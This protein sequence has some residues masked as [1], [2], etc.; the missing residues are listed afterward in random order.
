[1]EIKSSPRERIMC[2]QVLVCV[3]AYVPMCLCA[4]V[5]VCVFWVFWASVCT[6][7]LRCCWCS[8]RNT[9]RCPV[10]RNK[11]QIS[12]ITFIFPSPDLQK[13]S[14][15]PWFFF[16]ACINRLLAI[17]GSIR[18]WHDQSW[19]SSKCSKN[20]LH[21]NYDE[22]ATNWYVIFASAHAQPK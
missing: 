7:M 12:S 15:L 14:R 18:C 8:R 6:W 16:Y 17:I 13:Q 2:F 21:I 9:S 20:S 5:P 11:L 1:M 4:C 19:N 22:R 10:L 3:C